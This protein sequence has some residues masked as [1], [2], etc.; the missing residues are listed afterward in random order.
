MTSFQSSEL[1]ELPMVKNGQLFAQRVHSACTAHGTPPMYCALPVAPETN[2]NSKSPWGGGGGGCARAEI[3]RL[4]RMQNDLNVSFTVIKRRLTWDVGFMFCGPPR[5]C[6]V[7]S[8]CLVQRDE[9]HEWQLSGCVCGGG[10][11]GGGGFR[12]RNDMCCTTQLYGL[13]DSGGEDGMD[14]TGLEECFSWGRVSREAEGRVS[15]RGGTQGPV[16]RFLECVVV[17]GQT[18]W[19]VQNKF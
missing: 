12:T 9:Q 1:T 13:S 3:T 2:S 4:R 15:M 19:A 16:R 18:L 14:R 8:P 11:G 5:P 10:G 17:P 7:Y 6:Y